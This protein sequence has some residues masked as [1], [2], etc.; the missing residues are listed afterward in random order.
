[1]ALNLSTTYKSTDE[2]FSDGDTET[3]STHVLCAITF[4]GYI[5]PCYPSELI[6]IVNNNIQLEVAVIAVKKIVQWLNEICL[7]ITITR[8]YANQW[9]AG[10]FR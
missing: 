8:L 2:R 7:H 4:L 9:I 1:M 6:G 3:L 10:L 5:T